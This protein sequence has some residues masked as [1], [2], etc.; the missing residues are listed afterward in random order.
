MR[1]NGTT[2][3]IRTK[4]KI[5]CA[6]HV[7]IHV[8]RTDEFHGVGGEREKERERYLRAR[9]KDSVQA[10]LYECVDIKW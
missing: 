2:W 8:D 10:R 1:D 5:I 7:R 4:Y 6:H 9:G 3:H